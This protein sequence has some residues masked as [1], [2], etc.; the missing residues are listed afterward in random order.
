MKR[1]AHWL[2]G[3][4]LPLT[5][6][7]LIAHPALADGAADGAA[8]SAAGSAAEG[9]IDAPHLVS[10]N[11]TAANVTPTLIDALLGH[12]VTDDRATHY[13]FGRDQVIV[14]NHLQR[15]DQS[16]VPHKQKLSYEI[17]GVNESTDSIELWIDTPLGWAQTRRLRV[18]S[19]RQTLIAT[20]EVMGHAFSSEW[21]Y[22][23][24]RQQP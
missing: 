6:T 4:A 18:G 5:M 20:M 23:D 14:V 12:W 7:V 11:S 1:I 3:L 9:A 16:I 21:V 8:G 17:L 15:Q 19:D 22:V 10:V 24:A 13:Y 2:N